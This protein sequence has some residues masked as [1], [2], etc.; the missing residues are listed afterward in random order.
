ILCGFLCL[1][2]LVAQVRSMSHWNEARGVYDDICYLRQAHLF[3][4]FGPAGFDTDISRDDDNYLVPRL[5]ELGFPVADDKL[6]AT[7][8]N[9]MAKTKKFVLQYPP[10]TGFMLSLFPEGHQVIPLFASATVIMFGF[11]LLGILHARAIPSVVA[12]T[13]FGCL[14]IYMMIN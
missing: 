6:K 4:R 13:A 5:K 9:S 7:C 1:M 12:T 2:L 10:G 11:A 8:H 3:Q 14:A